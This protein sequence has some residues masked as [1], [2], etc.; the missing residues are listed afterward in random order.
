[1]IFESTANERRQ[2]RWTGKALRVATHLGVDH[3]MPRRSSAR[4]PSTSARAALGDEGYEAAVRN[5]E[6][7]SREE[8]VE[9]ALSIPTE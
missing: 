9:L 7:L 4:T 8:E 6:A 2:I 3:L 5:G 1:V